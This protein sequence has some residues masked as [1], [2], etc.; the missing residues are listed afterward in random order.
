M[1]DD[2]DLAGLYDPAEFGSRATLKKQGQSK[3][4]DG[5]I[6]DQKSGNRLSGHSSERGGLRVKAAG[7]V[8]QIPAS[9]VPT[10]WQD[11]TIELSDGANAVQQ[12]SIV[13]ATSPQS[14]SCDLVLTPY[15]HR[16][17][18]HGQWLRDEN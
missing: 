18:T 1:L 4:V 10:D 13:D 15:K 16:T 2:D 7:L 12:Y 9:Q 11:W 14:G 6:L 3:P 8:F 5:L 17:E